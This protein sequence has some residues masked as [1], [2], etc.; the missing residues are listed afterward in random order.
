MAIR[1][2]KI[3]TISF[4]NVVSPVITNAPFYH[5]VTALPGHNYGWENK[6]RTKHQ[7]KLIDIEAK[8]NETKKFGC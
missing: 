3:K 4:G 1:K 7:T 2:F 6:L 5:F 8:L